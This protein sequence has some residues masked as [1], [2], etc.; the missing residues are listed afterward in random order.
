M[1]AE[2]L[3]IPCPI[4][5]SIGILTEECLWCDEGYIDEHDEDPINF[6]VPFQDYKRCPE[7]KGRG[8]YIWCEKCG[9]D[10]YGRLNND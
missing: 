4:C 5:G 6:S 3:D 1:D 7:C 2:W 9:A 8:C 10:L